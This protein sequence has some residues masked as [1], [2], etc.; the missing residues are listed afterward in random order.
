M[1]QSERASQPEIEER[2]A[3]IRELIDMGYNGAEVWRYV[4]NETDWN[5]QRA[6]CYVYFTK[7]YEQMADE[8]TKVDRKAYF[9]RSLGQYEY[10]LRKSLA[11]GD[12]VNARKSV[13][14]IVA[15]LRL[16]EPG[17]DM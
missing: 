14:S 12:H 10:I 6:Q 16:T 9:T 3:L 4:K 2:L 13:E 11:K 17:A 5:I 1:P 15:L 8:A 7:C